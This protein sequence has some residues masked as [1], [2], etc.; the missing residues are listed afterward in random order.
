MSVKE[1][2]R[3]YTP[4]LLTNIARNAHMSKEYRQAALELLVEQGSAHVRNMD[5]LKDQCVKAGLPVP[6]APKHRQ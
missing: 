6:E 5:D 4:D 1:D 2:L 3:K